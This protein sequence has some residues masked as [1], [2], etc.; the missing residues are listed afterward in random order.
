MKTQL[1]HGSGYG[2]GCSHVV[3]HYG[4]GGGHGNGNGIGSGN[5]SATG[6]NG[7]S[8]GYGDGDVGRGNGDGWGN[9]AVVVA[10]IG[11]ETPSLTFRV[12]LV[13]GLAA[14]VL[15]HNIEGLIHDQENDS[16]SQRRLGLRR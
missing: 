10:G 13:A 16:R 8:D 15:L 3:Y 1:T 12:T 2:D 11:Q 14:Q 4:D 6:D 9:G 5:G 7:C